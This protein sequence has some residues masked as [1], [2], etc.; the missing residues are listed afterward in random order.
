MRMFRAILFISLF[1]NIG[2]AT[3]IE[4]GDQTISFSGSGCSREIKESGG[5]VECI[6]VNS[7]NNIRLDLPGSVTVQKGKTDLAVNCST[8]DGSASGNTVISSSYEEK[9]AGNILLGGF[10]GV[11][12]DA[13]TGAMWKFPEAVVIQLGCGQ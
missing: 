5:A 3:I 4:G 9:N 7:D 12:I 11:G 13:Y 2:C 1:F 8:Q 6:I 10:I